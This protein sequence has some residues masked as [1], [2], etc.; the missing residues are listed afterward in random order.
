VSSR[1]ALEDAPADQPNHAKVT[2]ARNPVLRKSPF[3]GLL[4]NG[5]GRAINLDAPSLTIPATAGGN[6][7]H[8]IDPEGILKKYHAHLMRG[9][10]P[11]VGCVP[12][13]RRL[14]VRE[15]ARLQSFPDDFGFEGRRSSQYRQVGNAVPP[16]FAEAIARAL[17]HTVSSRS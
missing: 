15:S 5:K 1:Q 7:T 2:Y 11:R 13:V 9:G 10:E 17:L 12:S 6:R 3:A 16:L 4:L 14:T 8:I